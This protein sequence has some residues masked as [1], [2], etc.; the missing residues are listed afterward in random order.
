MGSVGAGVRKEQ[1]RRSHTSSSPTHMGFRSAHDEA[2]WKLENTSVASLPAYVM[3]TLPP[4]CRPTNSVTSYTCALIKAGQLLTIRT[5]LLLIVNAAERGPPEGAP[6]PPFNRKACH[7]HAPCASAPA[8]HCDAC[9][10]RMPCHEALLSIG[11]KGN[12][13][14]A[15]HGDRTLG[16]R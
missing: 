10:E 2:A 9:T 3:I 11:A 5:A 13:N 7:R 4:G 16:S 12:L 15:A 8:G 1:V 6:Q 14:C